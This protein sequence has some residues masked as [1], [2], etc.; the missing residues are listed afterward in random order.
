VR[1]SARTVVLDT[2]ALFLPLRTRF[3]LEEEIARLVPGAR[4]AVADATRRELV[5][6]EARGTPR[7]AAARALADRFARLTSDGDGDEAILGCALRARAVLLTADRALQ[8]RAR[9]AGL[10]VLAPRDRHRLELRRAR[11]VGRGNR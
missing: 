5:R 10:T 6:L 9:A 1:R 4:L 8:A 2:N 7:A 3:P 11:R